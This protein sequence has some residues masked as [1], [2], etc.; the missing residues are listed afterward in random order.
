MKKDNE[1]GKIVFNIE[2]EMK[3]QGLSITKLSYYS[4]TGRTQL[5]KY[6]R[7]DIQR[8]DLAVL[9]RICYALECDINDIIEY[10]PPKK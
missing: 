4:E 6:I 3:K 2:K 1:Y 7:N 10:V 5:K 9:S 8:I